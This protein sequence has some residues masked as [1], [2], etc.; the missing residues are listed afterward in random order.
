MSRNFEVRPM[1][2]TQSIELVNNQGHFFCDSDDIQ[3]LVT[4]LVL[5]KKELGFEGIL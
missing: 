3:T 2:A 4:Y 1:T 5:H